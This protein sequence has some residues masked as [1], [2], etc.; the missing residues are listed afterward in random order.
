VIDEAE[1]VLR[2]PTSA[3]FRVGE[4]SAVFLVKDGVAQRHEVTIGRQNGIEAEVIE[5]LSEGDEIVLH[6]SD[7]IEDGVKVKQRNVES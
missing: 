4:K 2:I 7:Q 5:G 1:N 6:P 3:L